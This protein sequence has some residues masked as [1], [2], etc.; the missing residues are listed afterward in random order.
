MT[1]RHLDVAERRARLV[2]R[3]ALDPSTRADDPVGAARS[4]VAL[5]A[6]DPLTVFLSVRARTDG[7]G[8]EDIER[9]FVEDRSLIRWLGWRR[10][11]FAVPRELVPVIH[12]SAT[13]AVAA[14]ERRSLIGVVARS[15]ITVD[16]DRWLD[17]VEHVVVEALT[18]RG[19]AT[20]SELIE[21]VPALAAP[22]RTAVGTR[23]ERTHRAGVLVLP[24]LAMQG[25]L[26]RGRPRGTWVSS[27]FYWASTE[28]WL[29][30]PLEGQDP[31]A[32]RAEVVRRWLRAFGPGTEADLRW[33]TGWPVRD[34]RAALAAVP[35]V[36][37]D[38]GGAV[39]HV[40]ADDLDPTP[41]PEPT[42][43]LLPTLD[44]TTMG[45]RDRDWY[46]DR[47]NGLVDS[48]GNVGPT[49]WW[50]GRVV[51]GWAQRPDGQ[52]VTGLVEDVGADARRAIADEADRVRDW[53]GPVR[54]APGVLPPY[55][56]A[57][58]H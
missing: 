26:V 18:A 50:A 53:L 20:T 4:V 3:H 45:W 16:P 52:V 28:A 33:W 13:R 8:P 57:L 48:A 56:R 42:A 6:T 58:V 11:L 25:R 23:W 47:P 55:Q 51:G 39:G 34:V 30:T 31:A 12:A 44:P 54:L 46:F 2:T 14:R 22:V 21:A 43:A 5:H 38:L 29:G 10:T 32:A 36:Q 15:A 19:E 41:L 35:H 27:Q 37:V 1:A 17:G 40:L 24:L 7:V 49:V 9:A